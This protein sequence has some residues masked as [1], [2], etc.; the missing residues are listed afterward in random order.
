MRTRTHARMHG[1]QGTTGRKIGELHGHVSSVCHIALDERLN[2]VFTLSVD[3]TLKVWDLRN[4]RCLQT[5]T[6]VRC[7]SGVGSGGPAGAA[8]LRGH[9]LWRCLQQAAPRR[10]R[11]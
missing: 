11:C 8:V 7:A 5:I 10:V 9:M 4:H 1:T 2:Q 6:Q 3:R